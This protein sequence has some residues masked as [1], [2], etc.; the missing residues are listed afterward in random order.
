VADDG[1]PLAGV[2]G[3]DG[4]DGLDDPANEADGVDAEIVPPL[5]AHRL[6]RR[7]GV[8][9]ELLD[10]DVR[11]RVG[12]PLRHPVVDADVEVEHLGQR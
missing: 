3:G 8:G 6:P 1:H 10:G 4:V 7:M 2:P 5:V 11:G 9:L 12:V